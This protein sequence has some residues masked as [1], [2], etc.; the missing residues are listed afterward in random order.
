MWGDCLGQP[1]LLETNPFTLTCIPPF[2]ENLLV[3]SNFLSGT[4]PNNF[5]RF[6]KLEYVDFSNNQ[7]KGTIPDTLFSIPTIQYIY[8]S[9]NSQ[10]TGTIPASYSQP[11]LLQ[12][13][14]LDGT[15]INGTVPPVA[16]KGELSHLAALLL[17]RTQLHGTIPSSVCALRNN[18]SGV[19][20]NLFADCGGPKPQ[21]I[22]KFPTCCN[23]CFAGPA[24]PSTP[25][26]PTKPV[27][28]PIKAP[29]TVPTSPTSPTKKALKLPTTTATKNTTK[30]QLWFQ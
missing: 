18:A 5:S 28:T 12:A 19:L 16:K 25:T 8:L 2:T 27:A 15:S 3:D 13:L 30:R 14:Y 9:N 7:F 23:D 17:Q 24:T 22:C 29:A 11:P 6:T 1:R 10:I 21:I 20:A 26:A 4:I